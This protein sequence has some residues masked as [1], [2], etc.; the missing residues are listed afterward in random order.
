MWNEPCVLPSVTLA[1]VVCAVGRCERA[2]FRA[3]PSLAVL[4]S[5]ESEFMVE[6]VYV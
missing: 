1:V 2:V 5:Y 4:A 3:E 6:Q